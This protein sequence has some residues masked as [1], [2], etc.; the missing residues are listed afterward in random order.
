MKD[1][2][3]LDESI[4]E[5][6]KLTYPRGFERNLITI[7]NAKGEFISALPFETEEKYY[8]VKMTKAEAREIVDDDDD[9][10]DDGTLKADVKE[11]YEEKYEGSDAELED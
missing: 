10:L 2:D 1:Y 9:Y 3:R 5:Q 8:L 4:V 7:K 11:E 6:I